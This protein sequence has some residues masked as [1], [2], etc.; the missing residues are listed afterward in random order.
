MSYIY[1]WERAFQCFSFST[2][3]PWLPNFG[4]DR[5]RKGVIWDL[6]EDVDSVINN[7]GNKTSETRWVCRFCEKPFEA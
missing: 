7:D 2:G 3:S 6:V 4:A 5:K 1:F